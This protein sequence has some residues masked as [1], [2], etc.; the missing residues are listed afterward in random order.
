MARS[1]LVRG[2]CC[3]LASCVVV[4]AHSHGPIDPDAGIVIDWENLDKIVA[5]Y[6]E[7]PREAWLLPPSPNCSCVKLEY[8]A[9]YCPWYLKPFRDPFD[10]VVTETKKWSVSRKLLGCEDDDS[11]LNG[12][13]HTGMPMMAYFGTECCRVF[14]NTTQ[15]FQALSAF[16]LCW[17]EHNELQS[18]FAEGHLV[19]QNR[20]A[21]SAEQYRALVR[22]ASYADAATPHL[23]AVRSS[24]G[25]MP[26]SDSESI[27]V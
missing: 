1:G 27:L 26:K 4:V 21:L 20:T 13:L 15:A 19:R 18:C 2:C 8:R 16:D 25:S 24:A 3:W 14:E 12:P 5:S 6:N 10:L 7:T 11:M 22:N 23:A 9:L 17:A